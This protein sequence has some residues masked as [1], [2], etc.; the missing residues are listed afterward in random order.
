M[1][2]YRFE[3]TSATGQPSA[4][5]LLIVPAQS[6]VVATYQGEGTSVTN[7]CEAIAD[8]VVTRH[9]L[10]GKRLLFIE[11]YPEGLWQNH[12]ETFKLIQFMRRKTGFTN[13]VWV[14]L[15]TEITRELID[16]LGRHETE[17]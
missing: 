8:E 6:L 1:K 9:R 3:F 12:P 4:C 16:F 7:E 10:D 5:H 14:D 2:A 15:N 17:R 11:H 13:P